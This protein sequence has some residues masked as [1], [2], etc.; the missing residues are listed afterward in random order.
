MQTKPAIVKNLIETGK[1]NLIY[2]DLAII[3]PDSIK[4]HVGSYCADEQ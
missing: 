4:D 3:G 2:V 1:A